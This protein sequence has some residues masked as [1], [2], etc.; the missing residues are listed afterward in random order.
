LQLLLKQ[1]QASDLVTGFLVGS[2]PQAIS[3]FLSPV[4]SYRSDRHRGRWG[5]RIPFLFVPTPIALLSMIGLAFSPTLGRWMHGAMGSHSFGQNSSTILF[6]ALF[7]MLF[8]F[9]SITCGSVFSGLINDVV[10]RELLGRFFALFRIFSLMA[11]MAFSYFLLGSVEKH[12]AITFFGIGLLYFVSFSAMCLRVKEGNYPPVS[13]PPDAPVA[14]RAGGFSR[15]IGGYFRECFANS[16]YRWFF[17]SWALT[18]MAFQPITLFYVYYCKSMNMDMGTLGKYYT[19]QLFLSLLQAYPI[20]WLADKFHPIRM[21][22]L[23]L[24][25]YATFTMLAFLLIRDAFMLGIAQVLC[26]TL[27]G[28]W[29]TATAP[30]A[31]TL[32]PKAKY[33]TFS[34]AMGVCSSLGVMVVSLIC[35]R[36]LDLMHHDYRFI[37]LWASV[38]TTAALVAT[39]VVYRKFMALGGPKGYVAP[40]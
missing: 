20:G 34:S 35:G 25:L 8:E 40:E 27:A 4:I 5:R 12:Y 30:L 36:L 6:F 14:P 15:A 11:G 39:L 19:L 38:F 24:T 23:A 18:H 1:V 22:I 26:G 29:G 2:L 32:L 13:S 31:P 17:L 3:I 16:Y 21:T 9:C 33:A 37:Y 28:F 10:P 7:W